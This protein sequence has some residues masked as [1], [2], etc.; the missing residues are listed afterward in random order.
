MIS[1]ILIGYGQRGK[2]YADCLQKMNRGELVAVCDKAQSKLELAKKNYGLR[3]AQLYGNSDALFAKGKI[4][5][6]AIIA[7]MDQYHYEQVIKALNLG[8]HLLLEKPIAQTERQ[9]IEIAELAKRMNRKVYVCHVLRYA[10]I[11]TTI[12]EMLV[13]GEFGDV[14]TISQTEHVGWWHQ[15]H[16]F[17][18]GNWSKTE[19][20]T[21]MIVAKCCHDLDL[22]AW[23]IDK[24][25]EKVSSFGSLTYYNR[26]HAP[27]GSGEYCY[28]CKLKD[29]CIYNCLDFYTKYP[30][31][32]FAS[33]QYLGD[34]NDKSAIIKCFS[35]ETNPYSRCVYK[36]D[37]DAVDHQ[38]VNMQFEGGVTGQLTMTAFC[39]GGIR[40][41]RV[42]ATKG[43]IEASMLDN[44]IRYE[45]YGQAPQEIKVS[46]EEVFGKQGHGGGDEKLVADVI[47][48]LEHSEKS[49]G[50]TSIERSVMSHLMG[51]AAEE[52]RLQGGKVVEIG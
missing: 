50:L 41:I 21:P 13:S 8:Y 23:L 7:S 16:S 6:L 28:N 27:D 4:A 9:C 43:F 17:V 29:S 35:Q 11:Y 31:F 33:G 40:T 3:D 10:P 32:A 20:T 19:D 2:F 14:V 15:A 38:V 46:A 18:R 49:L 51:F 45:I 39:E 48:D 47:N 5:D 24:K 25:C 42:H 22:F 1:Y 30:N 37:N 44:V 34:G 26:D 36:C 12:K 52:S